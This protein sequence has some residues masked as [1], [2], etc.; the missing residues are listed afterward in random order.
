MPWGDPR[1]TLTVQEVDRFGRNLPEGLIMLTE[2]FRGIRVKV[3]E[4]IAADEH[5]V[6]SLVLDLARRYAGN[7]TER[8]VGRHH[9]VVWGQVVVRSESGQYDV[10]KSYNAPV[11]GDPYATAVDAAWV[12]FAGVAV[13]AVLAFVGTQWSESQREQREDHQRWHQPRMQAYTTTLTQL[14]VIVIEVRSLIA[15]ARPRLQP[16]WAPYQLK[17]QTRT[18]KEALRLTLDQLELIR[19]VGTRP[20]QDAAERCMEVLEQF[21]ETLGDWSRQMPDSV[22]DEFVRELDTAKVE[23]RAAARVELDV[24]RRAPVRRTAVAAE[25]EP[26]GGPAYRLY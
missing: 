17:R 14:T 5:T 9:D 20:A 18:A 6:R 19:V 1:P 21:F 16:P 25:P 15:A 7:C 23:L 24:E 10:S 26:K 2:L 8:W 22:V 12:G 11:G 3:L 4:G 13:G